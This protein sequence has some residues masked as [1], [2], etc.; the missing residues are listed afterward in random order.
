MATKQ[1]RSRPSAGTRRKGSRARLSNPSPGVCIAPDCGRELYAR[2]LCQTH[3]RQLTTTGKLKPIRA[4]R[5]R[6]TGTVKFSG[7]RLTPSCVQVL[8][9]YAKE[10][11]LAPGAAIAEVLEGWNADRDEP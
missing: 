2:G 6:R 7:L 11:G 4:Y 1:K 3:H 8:E 5:Q 10:R 9:A